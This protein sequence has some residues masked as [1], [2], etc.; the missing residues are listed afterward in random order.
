MSKKAIKPD[1]IID[2]LNDEKVVN[3]LLLKIQDKLSQSILDKLQGNLSATLGNIIDDKLD[4][5]KS[6][7]DLKFDSLKSQ[8]CESLNDTINNLIDNKVKAISTTFQS[9]IDSL[10]K[11]LSHLENLSFRNDIIISGFKPK[12]DAPLMESVMDLLNVDLN[13]QLTSKDFNYMFIMKNKVSPQ[14]SSQIHLPPVVV[15]FS[16]QHL[17]NDLLAKVKHIRKQKLRSD[18]TSP[19]IYY[20]ERLSKSVQEIFYQ[21]RLLVKEKR[22]LSTWAFKGEIYIKKE[23]TSSPRRILSV[24]DLKEYR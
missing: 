20:N 24:N 5:W 1:D 19:R 23:N 13:L 4:K 11:R 22:L 12:K 14:S 3:A 9:K 21:S 17:R 18:N 15:G 16:S 10:D 2:S 8:I 7:N 6:N